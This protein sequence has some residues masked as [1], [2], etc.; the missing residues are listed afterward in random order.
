MMS[1][2]QGTFIEINLK[3]LENNFNYIKSIISKNTKILAVV[4]ACAYGSD[5]VRISKF[6][7]KLNVDYFAVAYI[8]EAIKI[9]EAG[10]KKPILIFHPQ[11]NNFAD[12]IK[13]NL[14]PTLYSFRILN[15]FKD[16]LNDISEFLEIYST[17]FDE[18]E[19]GDEIEVIITQVNN[20]DFIIKGSVDAICCK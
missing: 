10:V 12:I 6:L 1:N 11:P 7:E 19:K 20:D 9:R 16:S 5:L 8:S 14:T 15:L 17:I 13:Y 3:S 4:K 2:N 18:L